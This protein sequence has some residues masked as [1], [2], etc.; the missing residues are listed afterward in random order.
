MVAVNHTGAFGSEAQLLV[1]SVVLGAGQAKL[2]VWTRNNLLCGFAV[3]GGLHHRQNGH[4]A[5]REHG[6]YSDHG[7]SYSSRRW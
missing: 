1:A 7:R 3:A 4:L 2:E 5:G 6:R